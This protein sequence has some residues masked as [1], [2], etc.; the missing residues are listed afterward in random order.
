MEIIEKYGKYVGVVVTV[1]GFLFGI[2]VRFLMDEMEMQWIK[3]RLKE[4]VKIIHKHEERLQE[5]EKCK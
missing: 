2:Y 3:E 4:E 5:L 1:A